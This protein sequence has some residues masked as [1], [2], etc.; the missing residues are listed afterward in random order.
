VQQKD[1]RG[2]IWLHLDSANGF[3]SSE[4]WIGLGVVDKLAHT[5]TYL[6]LL[7]DM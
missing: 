5:Y 4:S 3:G 6:I 1:D 2:G 7:L